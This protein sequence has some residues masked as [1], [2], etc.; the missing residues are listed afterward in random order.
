MGRPYAG[1]LGE[2]DATY[3]WSLAVPVTDLA[4]SVAGSMRRSLVIV[5]SGG[6]LTAA[7]LA[8]YMHTRFTGQAAQT[9]TPYEFTSS[10]RVL[11]DT[12]VLICS[13]GGANPDVLAAARLAIT[14]APAQLL[15]ITTRTGSP[16]QKECEIAG[17]P[18]CHAFPTPTKKDGFLATNSL[19]ATIMLLIRAYEE[20][21]GCSTCLPHS[22]DALIHPKLNR[23]QFI[24]RCREQMAPLVDR[25]TLIVLHG[26]ATKPA[27]MD[28]ES[29]LTEA[30]LANVQPADFRN[31]AHG[32]HYW[33]AR[34]AR[35]SAVIAFS[36]NGD[37]T[38][39]RTLTLLPAA[40]P[41]WHLSVAP[42]LRG[43]LAAV[44]HSLFLAHIAGEIKGIDPGR[45]RVPAFGRKLYHLR[46]MPRVC[47]RAD[48]AKTRMHLAIERKA[49][50]P[51]TSLTA[52][53]QLEH[54]VRNYT[55]FVQRLSEAHIRAVVLDYDGTLCAPQR[56]LAGPSSQVVDLLK[57]LLAEGVTVAVATG[58]GKSVREELLKRITGPRN[59]AHVIIG[60]H[61]G[62]EV[63]LLSD[64][65]CPPLER[66]LISE[67]MV[68]ADVLRENQIIQRHATVE[69]KGKQISLEFHLT[70]DGFA[71][72]DEASRIV[73][74]QSS[75][76]GVSIVTS[77]HSV[78]IIARGVSKANVVD[79]L[80]SRLH[81]DDSGD[82]SVLCIGDRGRFPG[83]DADLLR[84]P[85]S[86]SVD[87]ASDDPA[88][89]W[90]LAAPGLRFD[91]ACSEY[92]TRL[93]PTKMGMRFDVTGVQP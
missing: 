63:G 27:A 34:H 87:E 38:A 92:L 76:N 86:L 81:L 60:Y 22:L 41:R 8:S 28:V 35:S 90:N 91:L 29:R 82:S 7:H 13:A 88:T 89:C 36:E 1:E 40:V 26:A 6:S 59:R 48:S 15:A 74:E 65:S 77:S 9:V 20:S 32:R 43:A 45:P 24:A 50:A 12:T 55:S 49:R 11:T 25:P 30:A 10:Q 33:L 69:A 51:V 44:C 19:L 75:C 57:A 54:W 79:D 68:L 80:V 64:T 70:G 78:D 23:E 67:L 85:L 16:L 31:F 73:R 3:R 2:L 4:R 39:A 42:D 83:N 61:N 72:L 56:R 53:G 66:P 52:C 5:G 71:V 47:S 46:A 37:R 18:S 84:H 14:R 58:R 17:W 93:R 21:V 62:A